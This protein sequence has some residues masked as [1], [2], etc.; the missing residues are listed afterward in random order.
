MDWLQG[1]MDP[2]RAVAL[3]L[4]GIGLIVAFALGLMVA[5]T[6][7]ISAGAG[8]RRRDRSYLATLVLLSILIALVTMVINDQPARAFSL[9]GALAIVRFRTVVDDTRDTAFVIFSVASGMAAGIGIPYVWGAVMCVPI[10]LA[11]G[12]LFRPRGKAVVENE[13]VLTLR[14]G[15]GRPPG[16][17]IQK[18][19]AQHLQVF[20][21][22]SMS[23]A[24]GGSALDLTYS[25]QLP[26][27]DQVFAL[28]S[29]LGKIEGVQNIEVKEN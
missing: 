29:A 21:L 17:D 1:S 5:A 19:L 28:V 20:R 16:D 26:S 6:Y 25:V 22:T 7:Y 13:G 24:R 2:E 3:S 18:V 27:P 10:V 11:T 8:S 14:L 12:W 4:L 23:T 9:V 15:T